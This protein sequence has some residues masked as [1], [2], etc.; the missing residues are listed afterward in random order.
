MGILKTR[1]SR[2]GKSFRKLANMNA[3]DISYDDFLPPRFLL[4]VII[5][6]NIS[7]TVSIGNLFVRTPISKFLQ[8]YT[9]KIDSN[10]VLAY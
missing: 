8:I 5:I 6:K 7:I 10:I 3:I 4:Q 9:E 1:I 2:N